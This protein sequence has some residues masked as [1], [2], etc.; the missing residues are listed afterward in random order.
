MHKRPRRITAGDRY[1]AQ[2]LQYE[3]PARAAPKQASADVSQ[4]V[5][6]SQSSLEMKRPKRVT[7]GLRGAVLSAENAKTSPSPRVG[8]LLLILILIPPISY[9]VRSYKVCTIAMV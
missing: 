6:P 9:S 2:S 3:K 7:A 1:L 4:D 8:F 5:K